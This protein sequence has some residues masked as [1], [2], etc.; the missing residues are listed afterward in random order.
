LVAA[1]AGSFGAIY[2]S[3]NSASTWTPATNSQATLWTKVASAADGAKLAALGNGSIYAS[4][5]S[6]MTWGATSAPVTNWSSIAS[7]ADGIRL[8]AVINYGG[9][10]YIS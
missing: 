6:G 1:G 7:S 10:V 3:T 2:I 9:G 5:D 8:V 4:A